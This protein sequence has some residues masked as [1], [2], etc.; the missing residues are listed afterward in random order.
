VQ[1]LRCEVLSVPKIHFFVLW[2]TRRGILIGEFQR[3]GEIYCLLLQE[4]DTAYK[5]VL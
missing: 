2:A 5:H 3:F 1:Y 4:K